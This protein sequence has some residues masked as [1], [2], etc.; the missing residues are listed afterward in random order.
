MDI[1]VNA[2]VCEGEYEGKPYRN[3]RLVQVHYNKDTDKTP[4]WVSVAKASAEIAEEMRPI[5]PLSATLYYDKYK[6]VVGY[7]KT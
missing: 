2:F 4:A 5:T 3:G 1:I 6:N 7:K